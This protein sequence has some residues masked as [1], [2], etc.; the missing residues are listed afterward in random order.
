MVSIIIPNYNKARFITETI[1]SIKSQT[2]GNWEIIIVDDLST[3]DSWSVISELADQKKIFA[4][5]PKK[6]LNASGC[7]N[8]GIKKA[9]GEFVIFLDSDDLIYKNCLE[10]RILKFKEYIDN[11]FLVFCSGTFYNKIGDSKSLWIPKKGNFIHKFLEHDLQWN[12]MSVIWKKTTLDKLNGFD[13]SYKRLQDVE[14][15]TRALINKDINFKI[16]P[17]SPPDCYYRIDPFRSNL[18]HETILSLQ[19]EGVMN[20]ISKIYTQIQNRHD[21]QP[22]YLKGTLFSFLTSLVHAHNLNKISSHTFNC[23]KTNI[24]HELHS[25]R[26]FLNE[27]IYFIK[28]YFFLSKIGFLRV[29]GFNFIMKKIYIHF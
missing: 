4:F 23:I 1:N 5:R 6:K 22:K 26:I 9:S 15:H 8:Y 24:F 16:F 25:T 14:L 18:N 11:D 12:I 20:Y 27:K 2:V 13:E 28:L 19:F 10:N 3:D 21:I 7:R 29:K 17:K